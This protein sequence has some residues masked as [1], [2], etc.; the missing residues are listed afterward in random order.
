MIVVFGIPE[1]RD[2]TH[3]VCKNI[4]I[5]ICFALVNIYTFVFLSHYSPL[6]LRGTEDGQ[7]RI[8]SFEVHCNVW[9][10]F[11]AWMIR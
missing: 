7:L 3:L 8:L 11:T 9:P 6:L 2:Y 4:Y 10:S 1:S 5:F